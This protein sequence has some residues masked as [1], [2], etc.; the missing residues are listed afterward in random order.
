[1]TNGR[2]RKTSLKQTKTSR[3]LQMS[4]TISSMRCDLCEPNRISL[5]DIRQPYRD[6]IIMQE[7]DD[8]EDDI[9]YELEDDDDE[10]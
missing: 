6:T 7:F 8:D 2:R 3:S 4:S 1:M 5:S 9:D 10:V